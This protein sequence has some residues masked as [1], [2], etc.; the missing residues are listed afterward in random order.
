[1]LT[2][3]LCLLGLQP[4]E[5]EQ[6]DDDRTEIISLQRAI[7]WARSE[8]GI[9]DFEREGLLCVGSGENLRSGY[10]LFLLDG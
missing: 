8:S 6:Y 7:Q 5:N 10:N 9:Y 4:D 2:W 1:M 3:V